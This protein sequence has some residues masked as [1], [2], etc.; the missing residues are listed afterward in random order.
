MKIVLDT[1]N[2]TDRYLNDLA[3]VADSGGLIDPGIV[4]DVV[5]VKDWTF[6]TITSLATDTK[7]L[8]QPQTCMDNCVGNFAAGAAWPVK[9]EDEVEYR[10]QWV[11]GGLCLCRSQTDRRL[12][13]FN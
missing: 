12:K 2:E 11:L 6:S 10:L 7:S 3:S 1:I 5:E 8:F 9:G 13:F 4:E